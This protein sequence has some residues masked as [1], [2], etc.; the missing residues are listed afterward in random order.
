LRW[1]HGPDR[2]ALPLGRAEQPRCAPI[3]ALVN[4]HACQHIEALGEKE[5]TPESPRYRERLVEGVVRRRQ[6][7]PLAPRVGLPNEDLSEIRGVAP[8]HQRDTLRVQGFRASAIAGVAPNVA[9]DPK[10]EPRRK[11]EPVRAKGWEPGVE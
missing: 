1:Q 2:R 3:V 5:P 9:G 8:T 4:P 6:R 7:S 10:G 11:E